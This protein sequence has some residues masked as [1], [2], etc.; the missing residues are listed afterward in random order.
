ME[1][2]PELRIGNVVSRLPIVQGGM[3]VGISLSGLASAVS[4]AGGI[5][6]ISAAGIGMMEPD[7]KTNFRKANVRALRKELGRAK[8]SCWGPIGVN[9][10]MALT[11]C[12]TLIGVAMEEGADVVFLGAGLPLRPPAGIP[13]E[14]L[15]ETS[16]AFVPIVSSPRAAKLIL[17]HWDRHYQRLPDAFVVEGPRAGG[18]LGF[19]RND[20]D[21]DANDLRSLVTGVLE[22]VQPYEQLHNKE[23]PVLAAGGVF[24]G[25]DIHDMLQLGAAGV[26]MATRFVA[27][28]ECDA[29]LA[30]K[31][32]YVD[33]EPGDLTI[34]DSP[35]GL[36]G[37]AIGNSFL[38][39]VA[40][41]VRRPTDC[42]WHCLITCNA[43]T[44]PY[45]IARALT[46]AKEGHLDDGFAFAGANTPRVKA[47]VPVAELVAELEA[48][49]AFA[50]CIQVA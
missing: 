47:I 2:M 27:T 46:N 11:D 4:R 16:T 1:T 34:I 29:D 41:G 31:E 10:M 37:R 36:P 23:I 35:L 50:Q 40:Q 13:L 22:V 49:Y 45:C 21:S 33:C 19:K 24:T 8:A 20:L 18:H 9:I 43:E 30:F 42:P 7:F 25:A 14:V 39:D 26:Q 17:K 38:A 48:Q 44:S 12:S 3:G 15:E 32:A 6:V 5:G 28:N